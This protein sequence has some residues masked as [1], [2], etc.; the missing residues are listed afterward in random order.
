MDTISMNDKQMGA[1]RA[2]YEKKL[3]RQQEL[4]HEQT[5]KQV[6]GMQMDREAS[7]SKLQARINSL[8][9]TYEHELDQL[10]KR[11]A[12]ERQ[13]LASKKGPGATS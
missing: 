2:G 13:E 5:E 10:R 12:N 11:Q 8:K 4:F 9:E 1:M 6:K 3:K 7:E